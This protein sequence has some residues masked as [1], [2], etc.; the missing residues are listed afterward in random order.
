MQE[1]SANPPKTEKNGSQRRTQKERREESTTRM[2]DAASELFAQQGYERTTFLQIGEKSGYSSGL[3]AH[4]FGTKAKLLDELVREIRDRTIV[5]IGSVALAK[6]T[7]I[8]R[9]EEIIRTYVYAVLHGGARLR[10]L[11]VLMAESVGPLSDKREIFAGL[12]RA[13][14]S[15]MELQINEGKKSGEIRTVIASRDLAIE[16]VAALRGLTFL[17]LIDPEQIDMTAMCD[18]RCEEFIKKLRG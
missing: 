16:I 3:I 6:K 18:L 13:F 11:F 14:I 9:I 4:R 2:L 5:G 12:N 7:V 15:L 17:W 10:A 8:E 1:V